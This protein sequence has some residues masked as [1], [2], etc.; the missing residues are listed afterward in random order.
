MQTCVC[1]GCGGE[2][3]DERAVGLLRSGSHLPS[4]CGG[5]YK[6]KDIRCPHIACAPRRYGRESVATCHRPGI[7]IWRCCDLNVLGSIGSRKSVVGATD[8]DES[9]VGEVGRDDRTV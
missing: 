2:I 3:E 8:V 9:R 5:S 6:L 1:G 7:E 4:S